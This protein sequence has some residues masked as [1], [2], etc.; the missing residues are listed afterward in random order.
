[1]RRK[2]AP[3]RRQVAAEVVRHELSY[4][5]HRRVLLGEHREPGGTLGVV[6]R[7]EVTVVVRVRRGAS[8]AAITSL[9]KA[10]SRK[11]IEGPWSA[12]FAL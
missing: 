8:A 7:R 12:T 9:L 1:M 3:C 6:D 11:I 5:Q 10:V 4:R 2:L